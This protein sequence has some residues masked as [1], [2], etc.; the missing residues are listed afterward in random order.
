MAEKDMKILITDKRRVSAIKEEF[1]SAYPY[2][3]IEFFTTGHKPGEGTPA[4][5]ISNTDKTLGELKRNRKGGHIHITPEM[6]VEELERVFSEQ[7]G[8]HVQLFRKSGKM[9]LETSVTDSWTLELQNS[10]GEALSK[11]MTEQAKKYPKA[12]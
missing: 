4:R 12:S 10:Q 1:N 7:Y 5:Y 8:L 2:L 3:K 11:V 9:W 6:T